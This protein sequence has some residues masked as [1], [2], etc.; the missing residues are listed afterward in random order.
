MPHHSIRDTLSLM[1]LLKE[2]HG[3]MVT[4]D[5]NQQIGVKCALFEENNGRIDLVNCSKIQPRTISTQALIIM[6]FE[7]NCFTDQ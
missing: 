6:I 4:S 5:Q 7:E 1:E 3:A 2:V